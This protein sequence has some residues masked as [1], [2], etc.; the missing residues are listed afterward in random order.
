[1]PKVWELLDEASTLIYTGLHDKARLVLEEIIF[2][3]PQNV[4][5]WRMYIHT[6]SRAEDLKKLK[7]KVNV[8]WRTLVKENDY[9]DANRKHIMLLIEGRMVGTK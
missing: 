2:R 6:Y 5:A 8:V 1:M 7:K 3:D 4:E 9:L